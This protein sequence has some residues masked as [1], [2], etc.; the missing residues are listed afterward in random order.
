MSNAHEFTDREVIETIAK[1]KE[2][3]SRLMAVEADLHA[4]REA[5]ATQGTR[6]DQIERELGAANGKLDRLLETATTFT[7]G[8]GGAAAVGAGATGGGLMILYAIARFVF[9]WL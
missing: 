2:N 7:N 6:L 4:I 5:Q 9:G 3:R 8:R 1:T